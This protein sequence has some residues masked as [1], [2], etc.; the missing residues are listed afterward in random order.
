MQK[1]SLPSVL[2]WF[3]YVRPFTVRVKLFCYLA[4]LLFCYLVQLFLYKAKNGAMALNKSI[5]TGAAK[6]VRSSFE[7]NDMRLLMGMMAHNCIEVLMQL[8]GRQGLH[9]GCYLRKLCLLDWAIALAYKCYVTH[10]REVIK[11]G[12]GPIQV[13]G[14]GQSSSRNLQGG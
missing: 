4:V 11:L 8:C 5:I 1:E 13:F 2:T 7:C 3:T 6:R 14:G 10:L 9:R 12:F